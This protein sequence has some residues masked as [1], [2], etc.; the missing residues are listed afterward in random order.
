MKFT[1]NQDFK[2][3]YDEDVEEVNYGSSSL[4]EVFTQEEFYNINII[5]DSAFIL[6]STPFFNFRICFIEIKL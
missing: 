5:Y 2:K 6:Y 4:E 3:G 1:H